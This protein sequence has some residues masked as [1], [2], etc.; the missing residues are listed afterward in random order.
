M[1]FSATA[2]MTG[3]R[4]VGE[5]AITRRISA[6]AVCCSSASLVSLNSRTFS[7]AMT[8]CAANVSKSLTCPSENRPGSGRV[9]TIAPSASP[10]FSMGTE[11]WP[12]ILRVAWSDEGS[13]SASATCTVRRSRMDWTVNPESSSRLGYVAPTA[14]TNS[15][16]PLPVATEIRPPS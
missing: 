5:L 4:S 16:G 2:S 8:A 12:R 11:S 6:V 15:G 1:A 7:M 13:A 10:S 9:T 14:A 3:W